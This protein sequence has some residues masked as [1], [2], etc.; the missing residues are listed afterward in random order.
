MIRL[1]LLSNT[2]S[3][4]N[5]NKAPAETLIMLSKALCCEVDDLLEK[6]FAEN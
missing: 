1:A 3:E 5:I 2:N 6:G 4:K